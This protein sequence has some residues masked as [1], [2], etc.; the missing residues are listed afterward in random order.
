M[1]LSKKELAYILTQRGKKINCNI[2]LDLLRTNVR[3]ITS[4]EQKQVKEWSSIAQKL[5]LKDY[6]L[7]NSKPTDVEKTLASRTNLMFPIPLSCITTKKIEH[8]LAWYIQQGT[9]LNKTIIE[10]RKQYVP[11]QQQEQ[12]VTYEKYTSPVMYIVNAGPGTGKTTTANRRAQV[13]KDE[14]IILVSYT[15]E[16]IRENYKRLIADGV[17]SKDVGEKG[18]GY[19]KKIWITTIDS[20]AAKIIPVE[21]GSVQDYDIII[22]RATAYLSNKGYPFPELRYRHIIIDESQDISDQRAHLM[23][24]LYRQGFHSCCI[25]GDPRQRIT[26]KN[27]KWYSQL[28]DKSS[29]WLGYGSIEHIGFVDTFRFK[30]KWMLDLMNSLSERRQDLHVKLKSNV[31]LPLLNCIRVLSNNSY[32]DDE[33]YQHIAKLLQDSGYDYNSVAVIAPSM[34]KNNKSSK[35]CS[36]LRAVFRD[37]DIPCYSCSESEKGKYQPNGVLFSTFHSIKGKEFDLVVLLDINGYPNNYKQIGYDEAESLI[38]V[39]NTRA[40]YEMWYIM[41]S[42]NNQYQ[43]P[44]GVQSKFV[45][46]CPM[47]TPITNY[48]SNAEVFQPWKQVHSVKDISVDHNFSEFQLNN[49]YVLKLEEDGQLDTCVKRPKDMPKEFW[50]ICLGLFVQIFLMKEYPKIVIQFIHQDVKYISPKTYKDLVRQ[51]KILGGR[52]Y[53]NGQM[54]G[55]VLPEDIIN[56]VRLE[57]KQQVEEILHKPIN[58]LN[59]QEIQLLTRV[60]D[61]LSTGVAVNRY[62]IPQSVDV[63]VAI[64]C[65]QIAHE[66]EERFGKCHGVEVPVRLSGDGYGG[67]TGLMDAVFEDTI[68]EFKATKQISQSHMLQAWMYKIMHCNND[69]LP[70]YVCNFTDGKLGWVISDQGTET[71]KHF[72]MNYYQLRT[73]VDYVTS[74]VNRIKEYSERKLPKI[75]NNIF[76]CDTE[77]HVNTHE[78][79]DIAIM[80]MTHPYRTIVTTVNNYQVENSARYLDVS[81]QLILESPDIAQVQNSWKQLLNRYD[82][83]MKYKVGYYVCKTDIDWLPTIN[84]NLEQQ[85]DSLTLD[86]QTLD[87]AKGVKEVAYK[88]GT[89]LGIKSNVKLTE[90]YNTMYMPLEDLPHITPHTALSDTLMMYEIFMTGYAPLP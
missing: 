34:H 37:M 47:E 38:Y 32:S 85:L 48:K 35:A 75:P 77:F 4:E 29:R 64:I 49:Q 41:D 5:V 46:D 9:D 57:E 70:V 66:L 83:G 54:L 23:L 40:R 71:W 61:I 72:L 25:F 63:D 84:K 8:I 58:T 24:M 19:G 42:V 89:S 86:S 60:Y 43:L 21:Y 81:R 50:G 28:W 56:S 17:S 59:W 30:N 12:L 76:L 2:S 55:V 79:M 14:G 22:S 11:T 44:R 20:L 36:A 87:V 13:F 45:T 68:L 78:Y 51:G 16:T 39:S 33:F 73:H 18:S 88:Y 67:F 6:S 26:E 52:F 65:K 3:D 1:S 80:N 53:E 90:F 82:Y 10:H 15:N 74:R 7:E 27:G 62:D 31:D 69:D